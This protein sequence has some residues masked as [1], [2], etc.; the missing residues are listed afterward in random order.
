M[1]MSFAPMALDDRH[2]GHEFLAF[3]GIGQRD[4][5]IFAGDHAQITVAGFA[6]MH[7]VGRRPGTG[8]SCGYLAGDVAG[9]SHAAHDDTAFAVQHDIHRTQKIFIKTRAQSLHGSSFDV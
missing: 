3:T 4:D 9:F 6:R 5:D 7:E 2:D 8:Q 1:L